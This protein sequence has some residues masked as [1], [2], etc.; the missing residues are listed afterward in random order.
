MNSVISAFK[1]KKSSSNN[2]PANDK[3]LASGCTLNTA[4]ASSKKKAINAQDNGYQYL[5]H[6]REIESATK[7]LSPVVAVDD[8]RSPCVDV[9]DHAPATVRLATTLETTPPADYNMN[10]AKCA[11]H[12]VGDSGMTNMNPTATMSNAENG[13]C[14][15]LLAIKAITN[16]QTS[17]S[18]PSSPVQQLPDADDDESE[19]SAA[20]C[21]SS[22]SEQSNST[23]VHSPTRVRVV[24]TAAV[25]GATA[26]APNAQPSPAKSLRSNA[27]TSS[28]SSGTSATTSASSSIAICNSG[29]SSCTSSTSCDVTTLANC[30][31]H[32]STLTLSS[33]GSGGGVNSTPASP[34]DIISCNAA[35]ANYVP[36]FLKSAPVTL[37]IIMPN[38]NSG[39]ASMPPHYHAYGM[40]GVGGVGVYGGGTPVNS[41]STTPKHIRY[42]KPRLSLSR[43]INHSM[44]SVHGRQNLS[45]AGGATTDVSSGGAVGTNPPKRISTHQRNLSLDFRYAALISQHSKA[46]NTK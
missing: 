8:F 24:G 28:S 9:V 33:S 21:T 42:P 15:E 40:N 26:V 29:P 5:R 37:P 38:G 14:N 44:P 32:N 25:C 11:T 3:S 16:G 41:A 46:H 39:L 30:S 45:V 10:G 43:F 20:A 1:T 7:M 4:S 18:S 34:T 2:T 27:S 13:N 12:N 35:D 22:S 23:V 6:I 17:P 31:P 19:H 36:A